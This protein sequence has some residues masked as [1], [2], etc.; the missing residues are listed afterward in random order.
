MNLFK[1]LFLFIIF[2]SAAQA[3]LPPPVAQALAR[4]AISETGVGIYVHEIGAA[5]PVVTHRAEQS[6]NPASV[7]KLVTTYAGLELLGPAYQWSTEIYIDGDL[8]Q[9][10][11]TG[12]LVIKGGGDPK[13]AIENFWLLL[14][15]LRAKGV[16]EIRGDL[17]LDRSLFSTEFP[18][19]GRFD[20]E[21]TQPYNTTPDALLTNFK[22]FTLAFVPDAESRSVRITAD[23]PLPQLQIVNDL[24]LIEGACGAWMNRFK[25][26]IQDIGDSTRLTFAG[27]YSQQCGEQI[28]YYSVMGHRGYVAG[29]FQHLW[30]ELGGTFNGRVR[31]GQASANAIKV[32]SQNS[33]ALS[34]IVR[35]INKFSNNV[36]ARQ[37]L[38]TIGAAAGGTQATPERG[39]RAVQ[40]F[41]ASKG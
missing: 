12:N 8:Q 33:P 2:Q 16:R 40:Q 20:N 18:D 34:E 23:P 24:K 6:L 41:F 17:I 35:D 39:A 14:R 11:L 38:L 36:M 10:I 27:P 5:E 19:P 31:E 13:F 4:A 22:T 37:L 32:V 30:R 26:Q 3:Q 15:A 7:M 21:A 9:D 25:V 1:Y 29:L 28:S